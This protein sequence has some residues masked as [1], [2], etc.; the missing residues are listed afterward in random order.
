MSRLTGSSQRRSCGRHGAALAVATARL[1]RSATQVRARFRRGGE[2][3]SS[4]RRARHGA[5]PGARQR[6]VPGIAALGRTE[7]R[8]PSV[9]GRR[10][11]IRLKRHGRRLR[12]P[13]PQPKPT[14]PTSVAPAVVG[15]V[16][17]GREKGGRATAPRRA[18]RMC[19]CPNAQPGEPSG[20]SCGQESRF[21]GASW[22]QVLQR[23]SAKDDVCT[24]WSDNGA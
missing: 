6:H 13:S 8:A 20:R 24:P 1:L 18:T 4:L 7:Q 19:T 22:G 5:A 10:P 23:Q 14:C 2:G 11:H 16:Q 9:G 3:R 12:S 17:A 21:S 15:P